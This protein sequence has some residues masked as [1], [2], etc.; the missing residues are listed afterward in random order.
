MKRVII[1]LK[2]YSNG[3]LKMKNKCLNIVLDFI[4]MWIPWLYI[5]IWSICF[6]S[7]F[8]ITGIPLAFLLIPYFS[9]T[10]MWIKIAYDIKFREPQVIYTK[11]YRFSKREYI[12]DFSKKAIYSRVF[13]DD[14]NLKKDYFYFQSDVFRHGELLELIYYPRSRYIESIKRVEK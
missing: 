10:I 13:F 7:L 9:R 3:Q 4:C 5:F 14:K 6:P 8:F 1:A 11:G 12:N 2:N